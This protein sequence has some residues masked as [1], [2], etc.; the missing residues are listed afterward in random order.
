MLGRPDPYVRST[1]RGRQL[2]GVLAGVQTPTYQ[3]VAPRVA[4]RW[5]AIRWAARSAVRMVR[6]VMRKTWGRRRILAPW[7]LAMA[8]W[9]AAGLAHLADRGWVTLATLGLAG[10]PA[11]W[12]WLGLP[13]GRAR[14]RRNLP[15]VAQRWWYGSG[16]VAAAVWAVVAARWGA[17]PPRLGYLLAATVACW[18]A[19]CWHH[20]I[21]REQVPEVGEVERK[22]TTVPGMADTKVTNPVEHD[23]PKRIQFDV[24]LSDTGL[25][26]PQVAAAIP[27]IAKR[28]KVPRGNV[29]ADYAPGG[30]EDMARV[31][32]VHDNPCHDPVLY[33][34][35]WMPTAEDS[36]KGV[37]PFHLYPNGR[38]GKVRLWYPG[39]G[40]V[41]TLFSGDIGAG[42][43]AGQEMLMTQAAWTGRVWL[44]AG[45]PQSGASMPAWCGAEGQARWQAAC[46]PDDLG[47]IEAQ[48]LFLREAM[49]D[50]TDRMRGLRWTD[51]HGDDRVGLASWDP[52][53]TG[54]PAIG[55]HLAEFWRIMKEPDLAPLAKEL[56]KL[57]RKAGFYLAMDTQYPA[58]EE[59]NN[60]MSLRQ[61][62]TAGNIVCYRNTANTV[63]NMILPD[64]LPA[65]DGIPSET[66]EGEH[67]KG[68]LTVASQAP[69]SSLAVYSRS[70][71]VERSTFWAKRAAVRMP[72]LEPELQ[73]ILGKYMATP[74]ETPAE[75]QREVV[76]VSAPR[77]AGRE[78]NFDRIV[79]Y[80]ASTPD[81]RAHTGVIADALGLPLPRVSEALSRGAKR[82]VRQVRQG[83]WALNT[84]ASTATEEAA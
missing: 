54:W 6:R 12:W 83:V 52:D 10:A 27:H 46:E 28:F 34:E 61:P 18:A 15:T 37:V 20:R 40:T 63:K 30:L 82:G 43:S 73:K 70:A 69:K 48:L 66:P 65:P 53:V 38:R 17:G 49:Y 44:M 60:D 29:L 25:L 47:P 31:E 35:S 32:I 80:L 51:R 79:A 45:D 64:G 36:A 42:K 8:I 41:N 84:E 59:F 62:L 9:T 74:A 55:L 4:W 33:D 11:L 19:W 16:Y 78:T 24:D 23:S 5:R 26:V 7:F 21:R 72:E 14:R 13:A 76:T 81:R 67:T 3:V 57:M 58:I 22:W 68:T 50:R 2:F 71:W 1:G 77:P 75:P 56:L 39:A